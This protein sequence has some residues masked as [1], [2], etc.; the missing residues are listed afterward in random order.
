M[1]QKIA[2]NR[3]TQKG[4]AQFCANWSLRMIAQRAIFLHKNVAQRKQ[5]FALSFEKFCE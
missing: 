3:N 5:K 4:I 2:Q 1:F